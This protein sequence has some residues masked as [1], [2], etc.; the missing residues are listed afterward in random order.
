MEVMNVLDYVYAIDRLNYGGGDNGYAVPVGRVGSRTVFAT[1]SAWSDKA[2][3]RE[4]MSRMESFDEGEGWPFVDSRAAG[5]AV[6][7]DWIAGHHPKLGIC[8][9]EVECVPILVDE[10][11]LGE[12]EDRRIELHEEW[13]GSRPRLVVRSAPLRTGQRGRTR[14]DSPIDPGNAGDSGVPRF[15]VMDDGSIAFVGQE[16]TLGGVASNWPVYLE[17][18]ATIPGVEFRIVRLDGSVGP[19]EGGTGDVGT[20]TPPNVTEPPETPVSDL[21]GQLKDLQMKYAV[22]DLR[23]REL[24]KAGS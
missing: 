20:G 2:V 10:V 4:P 14:L 19:P 9:C 12:L 8:E 3:E 6:G 15:A 23:V 21:E 5:G 17:M 22:L 18:L 16:I 24:E 7:V 1:F 11:A 13:V